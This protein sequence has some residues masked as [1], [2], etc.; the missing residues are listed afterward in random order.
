MPFLL[1]PF[2]ASMRHACLRGALLFLACCAFVFADIST[3]LLHAQSLSIESLDAQ[4]FPTLRAQVYAFDANGNRLTDAAGFTLTEDGVRRT[5]R[6]FVCPPPNPA[7]LSAVLTIDVSGSMQEPRGQGM[8]RY[9]PMNVV[10]EAA[11][12]FVDALQNDGSE[13]AITLFNHSN[14]IINPFTTNRDELRAGLGLLPY[15]DGGTDYA[16]AF[17]VALN[18]AAQGKNA[19]KVII[20]LTD[21]L[22]G[23]NAVAIAQQARLLGV[24]IICITLGFP[25]PTVL[26]DIVQNLNTPVPTGSRLYDNISSREE[27]LQLYRSLANQLRNDAPCTIEW[28]SELSCNTAQRA[29]ALTHAQVPGVTARTRYSPS[30]ALS[31]QVRITPNALGFGAV[32]VRTTS[33]P[34]QI[35]ISY[36]NTAL[37]ALRISRVISTDTA[38]KVS[39]LSTPSSTNTAFTLRPG[40]TDSLQIL[41]IRYTAPDD[42]YR[43]TTF[44]VE[45][46]NGCTFEFYGTA[47]FRGSRPAAN[48]EPLKLTHPNGGEIFL[49]GSDSV[50]TWRGISPSD[51]VRLDYSLDAGRTWKLITDKGLGLR[52][53]WNKI[54]E[55]TNQVTSSTCLMRVQQK[56]NTTSLFSN[57]SA[58]VLRLPDPVE[59]TGAQFDRT[60]LGNN[61]LTTDRQG[62]FALWD[63]NTGA[64]LRST[65]SDPPA[66]INEASYSFDPANVIAACLGPNIQFLD[67]LLRGIS[68]A[69]SGASTSDPRAFRFNPRNTLQLVLTPGANDMQTGINVY[70]YNTRPIN[71]LPLPNSRGNTRIADFVFPSGK[72]IFATIGNQ[73]KLWRF[74][75]TV[76]FTGDTPLE[77][78]APDFILSADARLVNNGQLFR[79]AVACRSGVQ[80]SRSRIFFLKLE[81]GV[82]V[83]DPLL[84]A[85]ITTNDAINTVAFDKS[86]N[87]LVAT[88]ADSIFVFDLMNIAQPLQVVLKN[89]KGHNSR[90]NTAFFS[91]DGSASNPPSRVVSTENDG[92]AII[93]YIRQQLP[94]QQDQSDSLWAIVRPQPQAFDVNM[95]Q[96]AVGTSKDS[97]AR[98][99]LNT[100]RYPIPF[101]SIQILPRAGRTTTPFSFVSGTVENFTLAANDSTR[102]EFRYTPTQAGRDTADLVFTTLSGDRITRQII[103]EGITLDLRSIV[104]DFGTQFINTTR[105]STITAVIRNTGTT[106]ITLR[107]PRIFGVGNVFSFLGRVP[108]ETT[109]APNDTL[110]LRIAFRP[111]TTGSLTVPILFTIAQT[112]QTTTATLIGTGIRDGALLEGLPALASPASAVCD[113]TTFAVPLRNG[114]NR[115]LI[116]ES[117]GASIRAA[118]GGMSSTLNAF[119]IVSVPRTIPAGSTGAI[120]IR[121]APQGLA[122][123]LANAVLVVTSNSMSSLGAFVNLS[124]E[125]QRDSLTFANFL[126]PRVLP[127][128]WLAGNGI[129]P[130]Q[131]G[132]TLRFTVRNVGNLARAWVNA[133]GANAASTGLAAGRIPSLEDSTRFFQFASETVPS[134]NAI[135]QSLLPNTSLTLKIWFVGN[136][137]GM[138][139]GLA[140]RT[141]TARLPFVSECPTQRVRD[142]ISF[143]QTINSRPELRIIASSPPITTCG[144]T[145]QMF[146]RVTNVGTAPATRLQASINQPFSIVSAPD[147]LRPR[148]TLTLPVRYALPLALT[149]GNMPSASGIFADTLRI[150]E[151]S[152]AS[153]QA[154]LR[155][156][157]EIV[158]FAIIPTSIDFPRL[159]ANMSASTTITI[160][161]RGSLPLDLASALARRTGDT[162]ITF[163]PTSPIPPNSS[164]Q[165]TVR[166]S[167][168]A[169]NLNFAA[170]FPF[171]QEFTQQGTTYCS[172]RDTLQIT[173]S[174]ISRTGEL[175]ISDASANPSEQV[176]M[177]VFLRNRSNIP[178]GTTIRDTL[179]LNA[180]M[181]FPQG[182]TPRGRVE[183][184]ERIIP[185]EWTVRDNSENIP[186]DTLRFLVLAGNDTLTSIRTTASRQTRAPGIL[187]DVQPFGRALCRIP[188]SPFR[189]QGVPMAY[190]CLLG[191]RYA[192]GY[193]FITT[194]LGTL[195][196]QRIYPQPVSTEMNVEFWSKD[197]ELTIL[198]VSDALGQEQF[199]Q[200][201]IQAVQGMNT[202]AVPEMAILRSGVYMVQLRNARE[203]VVQRVMVVR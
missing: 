131:A 35:T 3:P 150:A 54:P 81:N 201:Q 195:S 133:A 122:R 12:A 72:D 105:D 159:E 47:G 57:D 117:T 30:S 19:N 168:G 6:S 104:V 15:A 139:N 42:G 196:I 8:N 51:T 126:A 190:F 158:D 40:T 13:L 94:L 151:S 113:T 2:A 136:G 180:T 191:Q 116:I 71:V 137:S 160:V 92:V 66:R 172:R 55:I 43:F 200:K 115:D 1:P 64:F 130:A 65:K 109:L 84:K 50:I 164:Q 149:P 75:D 69:V 80:D 59:M 98:V 184:G 10:K 18:L 95:K 5:V 170:R 14:F 44:R 25:A 166:F 45:A 88:A 162:A 111:N 31:S 20:F 124:A 9:I 11:T 152:T 142:T 128:R 135:P 36:S 86:G 17:S 112:G 155:V 186:I 89:K 68:P 28:T 171:F 163:S 123:G 118:S 202:L 33:G 67:S 161:N 53:V 46:E 192:T 70:S 23:A 194:P 165:V 132:D 181:L 145:G 153:V 73:F 147:T 140:G 197:A 143:S 39:L 100:E 167:G 177:F 37:P 127:N 134:G 83:E 91:W 99:L 129:E 32:P 179:R 102:V 175:S 74:R 97:T 114:G 34:Q 189:L 58:I 22:S 188:D 77:W 120:L 56:N 110:Q 106:P 183:F 198:R 144:N 182:R 169:G 49:L 85:P 176:Q 178:L 7:P 24:K 63:G 87:Y 101:R 93:W 96:A 61:V 146:V 141:Y 199:P 26:R 108:M 60:I 4:N 90:V 78:T 121:F 38:F 203:L 148:D 185:V 29:V 174:T 48:A 107:N 21:G 79:I 52:H 173:A 27:A 193:G 82:L 156:Q 157:R 41:N 154:A 62:R 119:S 138:N 76:E 103:G 16:T 125:I 187:I